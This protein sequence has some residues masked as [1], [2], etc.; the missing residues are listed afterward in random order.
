MEVLLQMAS[1]IR[2]GVFL[3]LGF[4]PGAAYKGK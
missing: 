1:Y 2:A 3:M 4:I